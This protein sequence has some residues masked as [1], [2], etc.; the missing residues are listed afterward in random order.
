MS[1]PTKEDI[2][3]M[4]EDSCNV[5]DCYEKGNYGSVEKEGEHFGLCE[6]HYDRWYQN[7]HWD[8]HDRHSS[9]YMTS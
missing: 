1:R 2:K 9:V 3:K 6:K 8:D 5:G 7:P 4:S